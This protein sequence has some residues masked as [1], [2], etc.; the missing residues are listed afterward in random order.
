LTAHK[1]RNRYTA[2]IYSL[3]LGFIIFLIVSYT[4][5]LKWSQLLTLKDA[6][7]VLSVTDKNGNAIK[8]YYFDPI[9]YEH[10]DIIEDFAYIT[11]DLKR[12]ANKNIID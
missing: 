9:L 3:A 5:Q 8:P 6:G 7:S 1:L 4:S 12:V 2:I 10:M 11:Y